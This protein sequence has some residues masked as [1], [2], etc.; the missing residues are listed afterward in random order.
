MDESKLPY[1]VRMS[2]LSWD[3]N[4]AAIHSFI[5]RNSGHVTLDADILIGINK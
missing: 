4:Q 2:P 3:S 5:G 1:L